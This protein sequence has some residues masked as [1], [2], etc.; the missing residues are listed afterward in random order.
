MRTDGRTDMTKL[1]V[2]FRSFERKH[3]KTDISAKVSDHR[4]LATAKQFSYLSV[5]D[6]LIFIEEQV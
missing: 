3:L 6:K 5:C 2:A 4:V 1:V